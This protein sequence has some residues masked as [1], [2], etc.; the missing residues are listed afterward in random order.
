MAEK[1]KRE[2]T[3]VME[4]GAIVPVPACQA[5]VLLHDT[6]KLILTYVTIIWVFSYKQLNMIPDSFILNQSLYSQRMMGIDWLMSG[7]LPLLSLISA[8]LDI[9]LNQAKQG[10]HHKNHIDAVKCG[11]SRS[12]WKGEKK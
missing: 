8:H 11:K 10:P 9:F 7:L 2:L 5:L 6:N 12:C 3:I 1:R 4:Y